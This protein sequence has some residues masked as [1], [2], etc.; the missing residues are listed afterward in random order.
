MSG[1]ATRQDAKQATR[2]ALVEAALEL[3]STQGFDG[4]SLDAIC[5]RAGYTRGAFYV[6]FDDRDELIAATILHVLDQLLDAVMAGDVPGDDAV[7]ADGSAHGHGAGSEIERAVSR[8]VELAL[9]PAGETGDVVGPPFHQTLEA[10]RRSDDVRRTFVGVLSDAI[11]RLSAGAVAG[12]SR[13]RLRTDIV[14]DEMARLLV[15]LALGARVAIEVGLPLD[16][17]ATRD[18]ALRLLLDPTAFR[19]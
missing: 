11:E 7:Y 2:L 13:S 6:H 3:F 18:A 4:P 9:K 19:T 16:V 15:L 17:R 5:A 10:C 14:P 8:F 12:Q 1:G